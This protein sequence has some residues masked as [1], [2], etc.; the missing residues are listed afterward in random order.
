MR[1]FVI[2]VLR[3]IGRGAERLQIEWLKLGRFRDKGL[4]TSA[5]QGEYYCFH[6]FFYL[7]VFPFESHRRAS[8]SG[9]LIV[10]LYVLSRK[11]MENA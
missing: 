6:I 7:L 2:T 3:T 8:G 4:G 10:I 1:R 5:N 9:E 11:L